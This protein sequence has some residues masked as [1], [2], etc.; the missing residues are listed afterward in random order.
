MLLSRSPFSAPVFFFTWRPYQCTL[1]DGSPRCN[2]IP[3]LQ[4]GK[5]GWRRPLFG[6]DARNGS[7]LCPVILPRRLI[8]SRCII[9]PSHY[10]WKNRFVESVSLSARWR[11]IR[12]PEAIRH[13]AS[14]ATLMMDGAA[15]RYTYRG[16]T[17]QG[18]TGQFGVAKRT[19]QSKK[20]VVVSFRD[21]A[22][23]VHSLVVVWPSI[24]MCVIISTWSVLC[25]WLIA[26]YWTVGGQTIS[27]QPPLTVFP[28]S[29][30]LCETKKICVKQL[31]VGYLWKKTGECL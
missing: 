13:S 17:K 29:R 25:V 8:E 23:T 3:V 7:Y 4:D 18:T 2:A 31:V 26:L 22:A 16:D 10:H 12:R 19:V 28:A 11:A 9:I 14:L 15:A 6:R 5:T 30:V 21:A 27:S 1:A 24:T 20:S